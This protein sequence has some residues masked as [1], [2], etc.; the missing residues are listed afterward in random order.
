MELT[1]E[2]LNAL[3]ALIDM[4][5]SIDGLHRPDC[6]PWLG[7]IDKNGRPRFCTNGKQYSATRL[8]YEMVTQE[9]LGNKRLYKACGD[10]M[11]V[12]PNHM[13]VGT[14]TL[15]NGLVDAQVY[16][17]KDQMINNYTPGLGKKLAEK[18][19][20]SPAT[21]YNIANGRSYG[22][23]HVKNEARGIDRRTKGL[24]QEQREEIKRKH[25][26]GGRGIGAKLAREY[27]VTPA[28]ITQ[29]VRED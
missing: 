28:R 16:E 11:C 4:S 27:G 8:V 13:I 2:Q 29:I 19:N 15:D 7:P 12:N 1:L 22:S 21:V 17:I 24:S 26:A 25:K 5:E 3:N 23:V 20:I 14:R 9:K 6:W 10:P 18:Y